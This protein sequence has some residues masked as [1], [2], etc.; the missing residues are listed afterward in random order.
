[1]TLARKS[2]VNTILLAVAIV[3]I[4][5]AAF[6]LTSTMSTL[7]SLASLVQSPKPT[8]YPTPIQTP[9]PNSTTPTPTPTIEPPSPTPEPTTPQKTP[10]PTQN[11]TPS[12]NPT[13]TPIPTPQPPG[14]SVS[15]TE[16]SLSA[17][18]CCCQGTK[19]VFEIF[20]TTQTDYIRMAVGEIYQDRGWARNP[21]S[22]VAYYTGG[23]IDFSIQYSTKTQ[24]SVNIRFADTWQGSIPTIV[25]SNKIDLAQL[26]PMYY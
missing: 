6:F 26:L 3:G 12:T 22:P 13:P 10:N 19:V 9:N 16:P 21:S 15:I 7:P 8:I 18:G 20:G 14:L 5:V 23:N 17:E 4:I 24:S 11:P 25:Y 2:R 1:M